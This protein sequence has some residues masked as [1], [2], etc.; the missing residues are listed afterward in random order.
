MYK[1]APGANPEGASVQEEIPPTEG[2]DQKSNGKTVEGE[3]VDDKK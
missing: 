3:V 1:D 2:E